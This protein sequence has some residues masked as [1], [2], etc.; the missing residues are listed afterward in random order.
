MNSDSDTQHQP[1][2]VIQSKDNSLLKR[3]R[4][5]QSGARAYSDASEL[6][7]E[8][9][10][11]CSAAFDKGVELEHLVC[12]QSYRL[13]QL[14]QAY[15]LWL[16]KAKRVSILHDSLFK[17]ISTL[18]SPANV[19]FLVSS[20]KVQAL[21]PLLSSVVLDRVQD[22]GNVGS[23]LR[24]AA[25]F[26]YQQ[27]IALQGTAGLW[28]TKVLR[29]GMGAHFSLQL[30][31]SASV[32][33]VR[34]LQVPLLCTSS[35]QG[36]YLHDLQLTRRIPAPCAWVFGH[37]GQGVRDEL[38]GM[39]TQSVKIAQPSGEES[40]NVAAATAICLYAGISQHQK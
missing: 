29:A 3:I 10:H 25:A 26:G 15:P 22:A 16:Q 38:L 14:A 6:W 36:E 35:H 32:E 11:L 31:E 1:L 24:S 2:E 28:S 8:G 5:I 17:L 34:R 27:I 20:P 18:P 21:N 7:L 12:T 9:E 39:A 13:E 40:L 23:I 19:G 37:E 30:I 4:G 33:D